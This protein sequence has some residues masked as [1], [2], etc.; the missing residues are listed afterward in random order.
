MWFVS[1]HGYGPKSIMPRELV[2]LVDAV[3]PESREL[4]VDQPAQLPLPPFFL[5]MDYLSEATG[6]Y[7]TEWVRLDRQEQDRL[8][9]ERGGAGNEPRRRTQAGSPCG[10]RCL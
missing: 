4:R 1:H 8:Q 6:R 3:G 9:V 5:K 2:R 10:R 7:A